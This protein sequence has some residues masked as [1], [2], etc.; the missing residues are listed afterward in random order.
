MKLLVKVYLNPF[1]V[2]V[3]AIESL[4]GGVMEALAAL[5]DLRLEEL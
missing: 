4:G 3:L 1:S 2:S 5:N